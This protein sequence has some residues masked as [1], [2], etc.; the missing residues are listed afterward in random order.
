[1]IYIYI[2]PEHSDEPIISQEVYQWTC[3][4]ENKTDP[5]TY[6]RRVSR[7]VSTGVVVELGVSLQEEQCA[8]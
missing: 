6:T 5:D 1:M 3:S 7:V 8:L 4:S 2:L